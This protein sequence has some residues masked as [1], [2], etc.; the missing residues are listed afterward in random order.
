MPRM[1][2]NTNKGIVSD[3]CP[4]RK[5]R[6]YVELFGAMRTDEKSNGYNVMIKQG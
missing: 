6:N 3:V 5:I 4:K 1:E 2:P